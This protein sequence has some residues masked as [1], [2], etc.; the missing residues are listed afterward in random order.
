MFAQGFEV[1]GLAAFGLI[2]II[3]FDVDDGKGISVAVLIRKGELLAADARIGFFQ[4]R[5]VQRVVQEHLKQPKT[6]VA[7]PFG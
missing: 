2:H 1:D 5:A 4:R 6:G 3:E 7:V